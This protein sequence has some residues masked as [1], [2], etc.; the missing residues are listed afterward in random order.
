M[1]P[2]CSIGLIKLMMDRNI[3][4]LFLQN[5]GFEN[6]GDCIDF[7]VDLYT[8]D[9]IT[10]SRVSVSELIFSGGL[11]IEQEEDYNTLIKILENRTGEAQDW[12]EYNHLFLGE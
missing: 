7:I 11:N 1:V 3:T 2:T 8:T 9:D 10:L 4:S 6:V 5:N 12:F